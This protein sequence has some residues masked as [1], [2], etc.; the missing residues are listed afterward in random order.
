MAE[1]PDTVNNRQSQ[2][3]AVRAAIEGNSQASM[4]NQ[5]HLQVPSVT[6][7]MNG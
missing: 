3:T 4:F 7:S 1:I 2:L 6:M 5:G